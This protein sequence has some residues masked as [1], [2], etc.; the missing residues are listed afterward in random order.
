[1]S[2]R[3]LVYVVVLTWNHKEDMLEC[4]GSAC[5]MDYPNYRVVVVDNGSTDGGPEELRERFPD[6]ELVANAENVGIARGYNTGMRYAV[7]HGADYVFILNND[8]T[9]DRRLLHELSR[10]G[11]EDSRRGIL[12][13]KVYYYGSDDKIWSAGA[14]KRFFPPGVVF[15]GL[16]QEDG[17]PYDISRE[18]E[19]APSCGLLIRRRAI[20]E[21]GY[22]DAGYFMYYDDWDYCER[23]RRGGYRIYYVPSAKMWHKVSLST[24]RGAKAARWW[25]VMG[26]S[27]VRFHLR[28][29]RPGR[30]FLAANTAWVLLRETAKGNIGG[31]LSY[32]EGVGQGL[33]IAHRETAG[34]AGQ[35]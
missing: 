11:E 7:E 8:T 26:Q 23:M 27:S 20:E 3:P 19:Y 14:R 24:Q 25:Q 16:N 12:M 17:P 15:I 30:L 1:M 34:G 35:G 32:L 4:V 9:M 6:V 31:A 29:R 33:A 28:H 13:P 5:Q 10:A 2:D 22:F 18:I 21:V